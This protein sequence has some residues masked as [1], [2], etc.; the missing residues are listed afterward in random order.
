MKPVQEQSAFWARADGCRS[1]ADK[2]DRGAFTFIVMQYRCPAGWAVESYL[3]KDGGHAWSGGQRGS[4]MGD[5]PSSA[6]NATD[7]IWAFFKAH[8]KP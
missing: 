6:I 7:L 1:T 8:A 5:D 4:P 3:I 2:D